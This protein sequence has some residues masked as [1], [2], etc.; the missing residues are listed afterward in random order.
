MVDL[1]TWKVWPGSGEQG[2]GVM[3]TDRRP[4][5]DSPYVP[6]RNPQE[7]PETPGRQLLSG[8]DVSAVQRSDTARDGVGAGSD[9][10]SAYS[11][12]VA[13]SSTPAPAPGFD[14]VEVIIT[15]ARR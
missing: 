2:T 15:R 5:S 10:G 12:T 13:F 6:F 1:Q 8:R 11:V 9:F 14:V 4:E 3:A 7:P